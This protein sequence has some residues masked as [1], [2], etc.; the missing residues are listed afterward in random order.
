M[1]PKRCAVPHYAVPQ[2]PQYALRCGAVRSAGPPVLRVLRLIVL[3]HLF[4]LNNAIN[5]Y[6]TIFLCFPQRTA[7]KHFFGAKKNFA[8]LACLQRG[9]SID[10]TP[11]F[12]NTVQ[13]F[14]YCGTAYTAAYCAAEVVKRTAAQHCNRHVAK[15]LMMSRS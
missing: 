5:H 12:N 2:D 6:S 10:T 4:T 11:R 15:L 14:A 7:E 13:L 8:E 3:R 1:N 9:A